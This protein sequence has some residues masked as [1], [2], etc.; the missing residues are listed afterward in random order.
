VH[1]DPNQKW[2][3]DRR[4]DA[5]TSAAPLN[6]FLVAN[7]LPAVDQSG[8]SVSLTKRVAE[9]KSSLPVQDFNGRGKVVDAERTDQCEYTKNLH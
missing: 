6:A 4:G 2:G 1:D 9:T 8:R 3:P 5:A 7:E